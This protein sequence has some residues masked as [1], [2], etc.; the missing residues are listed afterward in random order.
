[1]VILV[2]VAAVTLAGNLAAGATHGPPARLAGLQ[3]QMHQLLARTPLFAVPPPPFAGAP[4]PPAPPIPRARQLF[5]VPGPG[6]C[7]I[8]G[9]G[10]CSLVPCT[11]FAAAPTAVVAITG[12]A[13]AT[14]PR[15]CLPAH[16]R[17]ISVAAAQPSAIAIVSGR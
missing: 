16:P 12:I 4:A 17:A 7:E 14:G 5:G 6:T 3:A 9:S 15:R 10:G 8:A 2:A 13:P 1:L 11:Q